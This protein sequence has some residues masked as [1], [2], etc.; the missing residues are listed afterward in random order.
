MNFLD[1][2]V[3][4]AIRAAI[5]GDSEPRFSFYLKR[6]GL[7]TRIRELDLPQRESYRLTG[8]LAL[9]TCF[10]RYLLLQPPPS[11]MPAGYYGVSTRSYHLWRGLTFTVSDIENPRPVARDL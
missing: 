2:R 6:Y 1:N 5:E 8:E 4:Q 11:N 10:V 7:A 9:Q 3:Q